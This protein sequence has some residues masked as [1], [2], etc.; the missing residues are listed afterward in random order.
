[1]TD[2]LDR[3][4]AILEANAIQIQA[5]SAQIQANAAQIQANAAGIG[6]LRDSVSSLVSTAEVHQRNFE[7]LI[8]VIKS[9]KRD[10]IGIRK[11][12]QRILE[13]LFGRQ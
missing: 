10:I 3:I 7:E 13:Y 4:E 1:M 2:R 8:E 12:V 5:N 11:E 9:M 6:E